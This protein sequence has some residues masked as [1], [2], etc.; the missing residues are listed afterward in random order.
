MVYQSIRTP[1]LGQ[2]LGSSLFEKCR[3]A[4]HL[5]VRWMRGRQTPDMAQ[6]LADQLLHQPAA[7]F[8]LAH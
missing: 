2:F 7:A 4:G 1:G 5:G 8:D 3:A 6:R